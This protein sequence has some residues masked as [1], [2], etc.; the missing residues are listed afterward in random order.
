MSR[1]RLVEAIELLRRQDEPLA[2]AEALRELGEVER[3]LPDTDGGVAAYEEAIAIFQ[4]H[5]A[6]LRLAHTIRDLADNHRN[7]RRL[8]DADR[9]YQ[10]AI[11]LYLKHA[12]APALDV[13]N[14][15]RGAAC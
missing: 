1:A 5:G 14:A 9:K 6:E 12:D 11:D 10:L 3:S 2:F 15:L 8:E 4:K 7:A 13:A